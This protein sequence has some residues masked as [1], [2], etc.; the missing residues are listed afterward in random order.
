MKGLADDSKATIKK[1]CE[2]HPTCKGCSYWKKYTGC[3]F[4][5]KSPREWKSKK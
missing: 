5:G 3:S 2:R 1:Y 4:R